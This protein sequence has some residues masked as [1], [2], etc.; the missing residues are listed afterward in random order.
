MGF[1]TKGRNTIPR[2][3]DVPLSR[4]ANKSSD[5]GKG[6]FISIMILTCTGKR[7]LVGSYTFFKLCIDKQKWVPHHFVWKPEICLWNNLPIVPMPDP[8]REIPIALLRCI[9]SLWTA[10]SIVKPVIRYNSL[11]QSVLA[12]GSGF[13]RSSH[14]ISWSC[15]WVITWI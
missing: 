2:P 14:K 6:V 12:Y 3:L 10:V 4:M 5:H 8:A 9:E 15:P 7:K 13:Y 1:I 11:V